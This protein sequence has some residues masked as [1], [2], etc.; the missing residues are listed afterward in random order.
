MAEEA[1]SL[2][3]WWRAKRKPL[4]ESRITSLKAR[5]GAERP[6]RAHERLWPAVNLGK[7]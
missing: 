1:L 3:G 7:S 5:G 6:C 2:A 4:A